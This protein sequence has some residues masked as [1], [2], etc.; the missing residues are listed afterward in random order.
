MTSSS[1][2]TMAV[3]SSSAHL[4]ATLAELKAYLGISVTTDD[5]L[6]SNI[7]TRITAAIDAY[8]GRTFSATATETEYFDAIEDV[9]G[10]ALY[11][12]D[13]CA[14]ITGVVN[15]DG[16]T[17]SS[18]YYV[19][20]PTDDTPYYGIKLKAS[21]PYAWTYTTDPENAIAVTG[22]WAYS[23]TPPADITQACVRWS[24]YAYRQ[25]DA[26]S[27]TTAVEQGFMTV[28]GIPDDILRLLAPYRSVI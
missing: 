14:S 16:V 22:Y 7:L 1:T 26:Q 19:T 2:I 8:C 6:L 4:Y 15:G 3:S 28:G 5:A 9:D 18:S 21:A 24:A 27:M 12:D 17:I 20:M 11:F 10:R 13:D 23:L 25:K